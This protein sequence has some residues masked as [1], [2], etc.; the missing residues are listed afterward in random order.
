[1]NKSTLTSRKS[2]LVTT[3]HRGFNYFEDLN[4]R[5]RSLTRPVRRIKTDPNS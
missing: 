1:M 4:F 3:M 2:S 5:S